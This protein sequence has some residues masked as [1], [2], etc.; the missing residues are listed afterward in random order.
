[1]PETVANADDVKEQEPQEKFA[2]WLAANARRGRRRSQQEGRA[3]SNSAQG[4]KAG[5][6]AAGAARKGRGEWEGKKRR[7]KSMNR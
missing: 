5:L 1:M 4:T 2:C 7:G 6:E 3:M